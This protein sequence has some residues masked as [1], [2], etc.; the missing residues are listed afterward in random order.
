MVKVRQIVALITAAAFL[1][2]SLGTVVSLPGFITGFGAVGTTVFPILWF[3]FSWI[4]KSPMT[5]KLTN[6]GAAAVA[7][8]CFFSLNG[9]VWALVGVAVVALY[10]LKRI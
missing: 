4:G 8:A 10:L 9:I 3:I 6:A 2:G 7:F 1:L 5:V